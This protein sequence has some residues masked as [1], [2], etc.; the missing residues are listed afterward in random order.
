MKTIPLCEYKE[1]SVS[2]IG[3]LLFE[4]RLV[5]PETEAEREHYWQ[6]YG[7]AYAKEL[8]SPRFTILEYRITEVNKETRTSTCRPTIYASPVGDG[9]DLRNLGATPYKAMLTDRRIERAPSLSP[10]HAQYIAL[11][12]SLKE[13]AMKLAEAVKKLDGL[14]S[15]A[16]NGWESDLRQVRLYAKAKKG[17]AP[18]DLIGP[19]RQKWI[20][21]YNTERAW[22]TR[23]VDTLTAKRDETQAALETL[24]L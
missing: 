4:Y 7:S 23:E 5:Q 21:W 8:N 22:W 16:E 19:I 12:A 6:A 15:E 14:K 20:V 17:T 2:F 11:L 10:W 1:E 24:P 9:W 13:T 18:E 3:H